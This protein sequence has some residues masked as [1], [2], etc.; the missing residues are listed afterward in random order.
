M[1]LEAVSL[2]AELCGY[3]TDTA[4][5]PT[6]AGTIEYALD[7]NFANPIYIYSL[8]RKKALKQ[9]PAEELGLHK[10]SDTLDAEF[11]YI[12][13]GRR[14]GGSKGDSLSRPTIGLLFANRVDTIKV[15]F[16]RQPRRDTLSTS[17]VDIPREFAVAIPHF[18]ASWALERNKLYQEALYHYQKALAI[19]DEVKARK[20][21]TPA[22][23][24]APKVK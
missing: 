1:T 13:G 8:K 12:R 11:Y 16:F 22:E 24:F 14:Y 7:S 3:P 20:R 9:I 2:T 19:I 15:A 4:S 21:I 23:S 17:I 6:V 5:I 18:I 10:G